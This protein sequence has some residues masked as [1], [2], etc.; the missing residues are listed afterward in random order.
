MIHSD[1]K[2]MIA[3]VVLA[4]CRRNRVRAAARVKRKRSVLYRY[5]DADK[6]GT[7]ESARFPH[8]CTRIEPLVDQLGSHW[9]QA[10]WSCNFQFNSFWPDQHGAQYLY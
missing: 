3:L 6:D 8:H 9:L 5:E 1:A 2:V 4:T 10:S 7:K